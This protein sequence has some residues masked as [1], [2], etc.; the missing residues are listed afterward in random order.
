MSLFADLTTDGLEQAQ[1]RLGGFARRKTDVYEAEIKLAYAT[2]SSG[3]ARQLAIHYKL[4]DGNDY[5]ETYLLTD[6]KGQNYFMSKEDKK[7]PFASF[8]HVDDI[9][10]MVTGKPLSKQTE[11]E[12]KV[13]QLYDFDQKKELP[14]AV[15]MVMSLLGGKVILG[16]INTLENK[17]EKVQG[18][19]KYVDIADTREVN[20]TEKVFHFPSKVTVLEAENAQEKGVAPEAKFYD[21]WVEKNRGKQRDKRTIKDGAAG[22]SQGAPKPGANAQA[23]TKSLFGDKK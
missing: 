3:G 18:T 4:D 7:V 21:A 15:E 10:K 20:S 19:D 9:C 8:T 17:S 1:D 13:V 2:K 5:Q 14:K 23:P 12:E 16:I 22:G 6:R 11:I